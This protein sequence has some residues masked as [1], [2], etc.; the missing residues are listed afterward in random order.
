[1]LDAYIIR[2]I[3]NKDETAVD[4]DRIPLRIEVPLPPVHPE[5]DRAR[6]PHDE[7]ERGII[8]VDFSI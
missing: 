1:M 3:R 6:A 4:G 2:R 8:D 5:P 7:G